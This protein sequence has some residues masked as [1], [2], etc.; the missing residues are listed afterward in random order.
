MKKTLW[1]CVF[2]LLAFSI[3]TAYSAEVATFAAFYKKSGAIGWIVTAVFAVIAG[4]VIYF[5]GGTASPIVISIG[6]WIGNLA[7]YS[8]IVAT[9]FGLALLGGG[10]I[11]SGG[12]GIAGGVALLTLALEFG[13]GV[14]ID[15]TVNEIDS[16]YSYSKFVEQS[17]T[18]ATLPLPQNDD[19]PSMYEEAFK[20]F[21]KINSEEG[22]ASNYNQQIIQNAVLKMNSFSMDNLNHKERAKV[23]AL[24]SLLYFLLYDYKK[25]QDYADTSITIARTAQI[26]RTLPAFIYA[27]SSLYED[28]LDFNNITENYFRYSVLA[29]P[30]N[31]LISLMFAIYLDRIMGRYQ[32]GSLNEYDFRKVLSI[33]EEKSIKE[34]LPV[35]LTAILTRYF[36][37][38]KINQ[39]KI[40]S[41]CG[42][43][44]SPIKNSEKTLAR[45]KNSLSD[46]DSFLAGTKFIISKLLQP[47]LKLDDETKQKIQKFYSLSNQ[48]TSDRER[49]NQM[50]ISLENYQKNISDKNNK[51]NVSSSK[52]ND[53]GGDILLYVFIVSL[54]TFLILLP[55][56][57]SQ[58][59]N[60]LYTV[61]LTQESAQQ[62]D[63]NKGNI[64]IRSIKFGFRIIGSIILIGSIGFGFYELYTSLS[65]TED[66]VA[67]IVVFVLF[68]VIPFFFLVVLWKKRT[69]S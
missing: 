10:S 35:N 2:I 42:S 1:Y 13:T 59:T 22:Y 6:T 9:N 68:S 3:E 49:L 52:Q 32:D 29:E 31:K 23:N 67:E 56:T 69:K 19:G 7:G 65:N 58:K 33:S 40:S 62:I 57:R 45:V 11:A 5:T 21:E 53:T 51:E 27:V 46:Y 16:K 25:A 14:A 34:H 66:I 17:K 18:M 54:I 38:L 48:Y 12:L 61:E 63:H 8:G 28:K 64:F 20:V 26:K 37:V 60:K 43:Q 24:Y 15:Y 47:D 50:V 30:D 36:M 41:L 44:N 55:F 39:Q 4:A